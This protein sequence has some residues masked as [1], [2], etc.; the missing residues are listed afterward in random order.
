MNYMTNRVSVRELQQNL[1]VC[2]GRV[3][4]GETLEVTERGQPV[5]RLTPL[6]EHSDVRS[7]LIAEGRL[8]TRQKDSRDLPPPVDD[9]GLR[10]TSEILDDLREDR[11]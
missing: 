7:R 8:I 6:P 9:P 1:G 5:A 3:R 10:L 4:R 2:L 11:L